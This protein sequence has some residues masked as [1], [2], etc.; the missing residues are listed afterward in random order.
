VDN[1]DRLAQEEIFG[2]VASVMA[3]GPYEVAIELANDIEYGLASAVATTDLSLAHR[4]AADIEDTTFSDLIGDVCV[5]AL[6]QLPHGLCLSFGG[7]STTVITVRTI[8]VVQV[9]KILSCC[10]GE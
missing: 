2:P 8:R 4:A 6:G 3:F 7:P 1:D 9:S 10:G 5:D